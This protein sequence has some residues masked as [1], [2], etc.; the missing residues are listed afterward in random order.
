MGCKNATEC[1]WHT[2]RPQ[3]KNDKSLEQRKVY[4]RLCREMRGSCLRSLKTPQKPFSRKGEGGA[5]LIVANFLVSGTLFLRS[6][7]GQEVPVI[8]QQ[9]NIIPCSDKKGQ[10]PKAQLSASNI[11][12]LNK[13]RQIS[14]GSSLRARSSDPTQP[15][16]WRSQVPRTQLALRRPKQWG[17]FPRMAWWHPMQSAAAIGSQR[18]GWCKGH[19]QGLGL[20]SG[21]PWEHPGTLQGF[22]TVVSLFPRPPTHPLAQDEV[23]WRAQGKG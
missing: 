14:A 9:K 4:C 12:V 7:H 10:D 2:R 15:L 6:G 13:R 5:G 19:Q 17:Q 11:Q 3:H 21:W 22:P 18:Q 20:A 23:T 16:P 8:L 1:A